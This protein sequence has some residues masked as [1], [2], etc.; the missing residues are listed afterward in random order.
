MTP[1]ETPIFARPGRF[2]RRDAK[3]S[4]AT[5]RKSITPIA[6]RA[7]PV[8]FAQHAPMSSEKSRGWPV[9][10]FG[11]F[12]FPSIAAKDVPLSDRIFVWHLVCGILIA[13]IVALHVA[14]ALYHRIVKHDGVLAR[15]WPGG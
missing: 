9:S 14:G 11:L 2:S 3:A 4:C 13:A 6:P 15:I 10:V 5:G 7:P 8:R 12:T 1:N